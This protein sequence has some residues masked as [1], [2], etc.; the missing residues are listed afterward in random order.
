RGDRLVVPELLDEH[1]RLCG[2]APSEDCTRLLVDVADLIRTCAFAPEISAIPIAHERK[3]AAA[4]GNARRARMACRFPRCVVR[5]D[6]FRLLDVERL[7]RLVVLERR[8][9]Q[10]HAELRSP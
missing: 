10:V 6:L 7:S 8:A 4:H 3:D 2:I 1:L 5:L 9:L